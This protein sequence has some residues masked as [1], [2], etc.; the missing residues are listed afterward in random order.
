[1]CNTNIYHFRFRKTIVHFLQSPTLFIV[2][3]F[4]TRFSL[5]LPCW[6]SRHPLHS[7]CQRHRR[8]SASPSPSVHDPSRTGTGRRSASASA[9]PLCCS[10]SPS[11]VR[12]GTAS[13]LAS[14]VPP[15]RHLLLGSSAAAS[16]QAAVFSQ[17]PLA[18][19]L[20]SESALVSPQR[21]PRARS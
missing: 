19:L 14:P 12:A 15:Q 17:A 11:S 4:P 20:P 21:A 18:S 8:C 16:Q 9:Q 7:Y 1:M 6:I 10:R 13:A 3:S 2:P 5:P